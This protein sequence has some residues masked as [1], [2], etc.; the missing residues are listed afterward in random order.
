MTNL[1]IQ[2]TVY[3]V[4]PKT[5]YGNESKPKQTVVLEY[6]DQYKK[7]VAFDFL[8]DKVGLLDNLQIGQTVTIH[9]NVSSQEWNGKYMTNVNGWKVELN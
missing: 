3:S 9:F 4:L 1:S 6:G 8:A 2:G 7:K 5:F